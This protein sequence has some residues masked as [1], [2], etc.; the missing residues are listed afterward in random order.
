MSILEKK[1]KSD[2]QK[3]SK[4]KKVVDATSKVK[5]L[6]SVDSKVLKVSSLRKKTVISEEK[7]LD[8]YCVAATLYGEA[9]DLDEKGITRVAETIRNRHKYYSKEK[10]V[11]VEKITY[12]DI[13][14]APNQYQAFNAYKKKNV[15]DFDEYTKKLSPAEKTK[16]DRCM[17]IAK[18]VVNGRLKTD[19]ANGAL[20]FNKASVSVNKR[21]FKT[22]NVFKDD[23]H[24]A[25]NPTKNS[26]H[27]FIG[28]YNLS[29][30]ITSKGKLL[31]KGGNPKDSGKLLV[32]NRANQNIRG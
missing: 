23:S 31:A 30:L 26:P 10:A 13:V 14:A 19:Y 15:K 20:G 9:G 29:P 1:I 27:V 24:Y 5:K 17:R 21:T 3:A 12:R 2:V 28:D 16:W 7:K 18:Q 8:I 11:D 6:T 32:Q 22:T 4:V 25:D